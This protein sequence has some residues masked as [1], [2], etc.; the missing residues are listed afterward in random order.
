[1]LYL[2][3]SMYD[4]GIGTREDKKLAFR[5]HK[6]A[7]SFGSTDALDRLVEMAAGSPGLMGGLKKEFR[8]SYQ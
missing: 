3:A 2:L 4:Q 5:Y 6:L 7:A 1:M 8:L